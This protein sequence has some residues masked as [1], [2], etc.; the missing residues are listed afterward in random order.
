MV[1]EPSTIKFFLPP[2]D[3]SCFLGNLFIELDAPCGGMSETGLTLQGVS[4]SGNVA[5]VTL[6]REVYF[7]RGI[8]KDYEEIRQTICLERK[9]RSGL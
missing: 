6:E 7:F 1:E 5:T 9:C 8:S 2:Q 4:F 3:L